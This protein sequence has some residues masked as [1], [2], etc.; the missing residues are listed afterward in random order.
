[1]SLRSTR[2]G[3][4]RCRGCS[5]V[6]ITR[7]CLVVVAAGF[8][9]SPL[10][11]LSAGMFVVR[12]AKIELTLLPG[13]ER[14]TTISAAN[15]TDN[16]LAVSISFEDVEANLQ[17]DARDEPLLLLGE[18]RGTYSL[19]EF[20]STPQLSFTLLTGGAVEIPISVR[21]PPDA[22]PGGRYGSAVISFAVP[23]KD[24][25]PANVAIEGRVATTLFVRVEGDVVE[26]G[27]LAAFGIFNDARFVQR[28][29]GKQPLRFQIAYKNE[30]TVHLNPYGRMTLTPLFGES[31]VV[32]ID[33]WAVL[34]GAM[35]MREVVVE[36]K[37]PIGP[38]RA[39]LELN[40]GYANIVDE[41]EVRFWVIPGSWGITGIILGFVAILAL[42]RRSLSISRHR[43][44]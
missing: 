3:D 19:K 28:P 18:K 5:V 20:L 35:R 41:D 40:R 38:Y 31:R 13:E 22:E 29:S 7:A 37:L 30:G 26:K 17:D 15:E 33:P 6:R 2:R 44:K 23:S 1:M 42:L 4:V 21:I 25:A 11:V 32:L 24:D 9:L 43:L 27:K 10:V 34:P 16:P 36:E 14:V 39:R 8:L 12:P